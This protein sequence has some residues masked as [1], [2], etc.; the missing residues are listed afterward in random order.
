MTGGDVQITEVY[1]SGVLSQYN[2]QYNY[3]F[4]GDWTNQW[5][6]SGHVYGW[7]MWDGIGQ[8]GPGGSQFDLTTSTPEP[9]TITLLGAGVLSLA[10]AI[11]KKL[12]L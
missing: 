9:G 12:L 7:N 4:V 10:G 6:T 2:Y 8:Q 3:D 5:N 11:Y 1:Y